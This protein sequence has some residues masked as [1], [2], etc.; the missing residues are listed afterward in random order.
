MSHHHYPF[1]MKQL[2][3]MG[4]FRGYA[5]IFNH[6]DHEKDRVL[7]GAFSSF[8]KNLKTKNDYPK[9]LWQ[10][11]PSWPIG[12]WQKI[13]EC[14]EGLYVEGRLFLELE[15]AREAYFLLKEKVIDALSIGYKVVRS[16]AG[17]GCRL[18]EELLLL[19][20]SLVTFPANPRARILEVKQEP[21][22]MPSVPSQLEEMKQTLEK[23]TRQLLRASRFS[24]L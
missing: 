17:K 21:S 20:I 7:P 16:G 18:L 3:E 9:M 23:A 2:S 5:S 6:L 10:H 14:P 15:K 8:L 4:T 13:E 1:H 19:E 22:L 24:D 12:R 11:N